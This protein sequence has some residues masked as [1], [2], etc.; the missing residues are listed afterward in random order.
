MDQDSSRR[1]GANLDGIGTQ[2]RPDTSIGK[3]G[4]VIRPNAE[5]LHAVTEQPGPLINTRNEA[6][7]LQRLRKEIVE[8]RKQLAKANRTSTILAVAGIASSII[9]FILGLLICP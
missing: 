2:F 1:I 4:T 7:E 5:A 3:L 6:F 9:C 8:L